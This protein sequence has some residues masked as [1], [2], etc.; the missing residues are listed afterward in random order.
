[1]VRV[2]YG[3]LE[4]EVIAEMVLQDELWTRLPYAECRLRLEEQEYS[5]AIHQESRITHV[6][7]SK[8]GVAQKLPNTTCDTR[9]RCESY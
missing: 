7:G 9:V 1:M 4:W 3:V 8:T 6:R 2:L 5:V